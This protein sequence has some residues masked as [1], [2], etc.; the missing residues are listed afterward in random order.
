M[1]QVDQFS[2]QASATLNSAGGASFSGF[3]VFDSAGNLL[4]DA[5]LTIT[6]AVPRPSAFLP[7]LASLVLVVAARNRRYLLSVI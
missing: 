2:A 3:Q 1:P 4:P 6:E 7:C 5:T